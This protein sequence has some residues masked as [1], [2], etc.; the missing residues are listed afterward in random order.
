MA[1]L[2]MQRPATRNPIG[3]GQYTIREVRPPRKDVVERQ[4]PGHTERDFRGDL[5]KAT[6]RAT[7]T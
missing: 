7:K 5:A 4:D 1:K 2:K 6:E 3:N